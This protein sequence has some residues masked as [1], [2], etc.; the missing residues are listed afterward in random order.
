M[1]IFDDI[2]H[3][4]RQFYIVQPQ[5]KHELRN[6]IELYQNNKKDI[7][8]CLSESVTQRNLDRNFSRENTSAERSRRKIY[9]YLLKVTKWSWNIVY[10]WCILRLMEKVFRNHISTCNDKWKRCNRLYSSRNKLLDYAD[11]QNH[12]NSLKCFIII[13]R[14]K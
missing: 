7:F 1:F 4:M 12:F 11:L 8:S 13:N 5:F 6:T 9:L 3:A 2:F 14:M 10:M